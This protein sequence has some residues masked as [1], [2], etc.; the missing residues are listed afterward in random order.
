MML[1]LTQEEVRRNGERSM[2]RPR[3]TRSPR[4]RMDRVLWFNMGPSMDSAGPVPHIVFFASP[5]YLSSSPPRKVRG[6]AR[7]DATRQ[8]HRSVPNSSSGPRPGGCLCSGAHINSHGVSAWF[9]ST[10]EI[11]TQALAPK[12]KSC[13]APSLARPDLAGIHAEVLKV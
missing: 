12:P 13:E 7:W 5:P 8:S 4:E 10:I 1:V 2:H 11:F 3:P 6:F 9:P